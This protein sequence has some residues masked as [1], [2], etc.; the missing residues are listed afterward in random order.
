MLNDVFC[1]FPSPLANHVS[2]KSVDSNFI[3]K[4]TSLS[5]STGVSLLSS[6]Q[7]LQSYEETNE[8]EFFFSWD[9][10]QRLVIH[11]FQDPF[12]NW[13]QSS[14]KDSTD[15]RKILISRYEDYLE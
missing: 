9:H 6:Y 14:E 15:V 5:C 3:R 12:V 2:E 11:E 13:L 4:S 10:Q 8:E 1:K 7:G